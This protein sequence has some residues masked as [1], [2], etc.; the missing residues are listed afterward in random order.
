MR[1]IALLTIALLISGCNT[2]PVQPDQPVAVKYKYV[3]T[4]IPAEI[5]EIPEP[6]YTIDPVNSSD[7]DAATWIVDSERR[8]RL[9][10]DRLKAVKKFQDKRLKSLPAE[11]VI[12]N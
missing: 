7:K 11:D 2:C 6:M 8:A 3:V 5:L 4:E 12:K 1:L 9:I 10:E